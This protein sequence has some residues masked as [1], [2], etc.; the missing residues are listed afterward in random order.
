[1][2]ANNPSWLEADC[3]WKA[4]ALEQCRHEQ[5]AGFFLPTEEWNAAP[6]VA[7]VSTPLLVLVADP[8]YT[9]IAPE[10]LAEMHAALPASGTITVVPGTTHNMLRGSAYRDTLAALLEWI[11][12]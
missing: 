4:L 1:V 10:R 3:H 6:S 9:V 7:A 12:G 5:V 2:R 11:G 8:A